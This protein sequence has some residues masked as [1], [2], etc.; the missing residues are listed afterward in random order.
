FEGPAVRDMQK[1]FLSTWRYAADDALNV[2]VP[3]ATPAATG[4]ARVQVLASD[5]RR[6][7]RHIRRHYHFAIK[8]ARARIFIQAAYFIP[9]RALRRVLRNAARRGVDV[10]LMLPHT[11]D[12]PAVK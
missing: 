10:R 9:D 5:T 12:V 4:A 6:A 3:R 11:S 7:R 8:R 1:S 2:S